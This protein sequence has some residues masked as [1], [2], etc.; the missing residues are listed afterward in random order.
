MP[1]KPATLIPEDAVPFLEESATLQ[2]TFEQLTGTD[3]PWEV[4]LRKFKELREKLR[5]VEKELR[6]TNADKEIT[7]I[8]GERGMYWLFEE[9]FETFREKIDETLKKIKEEG[10]MPVW[11]YTTAEMLA[12][13]VNNMRQ[14][15]MAVAHDIVLLDLLKESLGDNHVMLN[16]EFENSE[17]TV[18]AMLDD[19]R[20]Q[21]EF[22]MSS[23]SHDLLMMERCRI[24]REMIERGDVGEEILGYTAED[25]RRV[26]GIL[27]E[28]C[29]K[30]MP[31][32][33]K[34]IASMASIMRDEMR[35]SE[36]AQ[37]IRA[38]RWVMAYSLLGDAPK[39]FKGQATMANKE[40]EGLE[41]FVASREE[42][43]GE[44]EDGKKALT[45]AKETKPVEAPAPP[46]S[47]EDEPQAEEEPKKRKRVTGMAYLDRR[48]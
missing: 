4:N 16:R 33:E 12:A 40:Q 34:R 1:S 47:Q 27:D 2:A 5:R 25:L 14:L 8:I 23:V 26:E 28:R 48:R 35:K 15:I 45:A 29:K 39:G 37:L 22:L 7:C 36:S 43:L 21:G 31:A 20:D 32:Y 18:R 46:P 13:H 44:S 10:P 42:E 30:E 24:T 17:R 41:A 19:I 38:S 6:E 3:K 9:A 11:R